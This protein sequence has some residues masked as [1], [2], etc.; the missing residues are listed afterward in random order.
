M[1]SQIDTV[2]MAA[3]LDVI[4]AALDHQVITEQALTDL[5]IHAHKQQA[6]SARIPETSLI[7]VWTILER[8]PALNGIALTI[9]QTI[10][11]SAKGLL[12]SWVSQT[13]S[14]RD[15]LNTFIDNI[16]LM[17]PSEHWQLKQQNSLCELTFELPQAKHYSHLAIERSMSAMIT[18]ARF[19]SGDQFHLKS[20]TFCF[21][22][23][24]YESQF[25][26]VFNCDPVFN[27]AQ[28][29]LTF[30]ADLLD[31]PVI[32]SNHLLKD[33]IEQQALAALNTIS[34]HKSITDNVSDIIHEKLNAGE[35]INIDGVCTQLSISRQT[36]YRELKK[37]DTDFQTVYDDI[38]KSEAMKLLSQGDTKMES[39]S[40]HLGFKDNS[41]FYKAFKR[42]YGMTPTQFKQ[43]RN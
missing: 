28:N 39:I 43:R 38:R 8:H 14:L 32:S 33:I 20:A 41:S 27:H 6:P 30:D 19:L 31:L 21:S 25:K 18:W 5:E 36:L 1:P 42:W 4:Q 2:S 17:N 9:G 16:A 12:A 11:P 37:Y 10:N 26:T 13:H 29:T 35:P 22:K 24:C 7:H 34:K 23:P 40:L 3:A 15:A